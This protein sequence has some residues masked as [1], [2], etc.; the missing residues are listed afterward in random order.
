MQQTERTSHIL[1]S[2]KELEELKLW[3]RKEKRKRYADRIKAIYLLGKL[4][5][6]KRFQKHSYLMKTR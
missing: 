2:N 3:H 1:L 5:R 4:G 6:S